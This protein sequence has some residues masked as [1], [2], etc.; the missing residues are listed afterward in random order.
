MFKFLF[1]LVSWI[2]IICIALL[3][4]ASHYQ[5]TFYPAAFFGLIVLWGGFGVLYIIYRFDPM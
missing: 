1:I 3:Y 4:I 5:P 2:S